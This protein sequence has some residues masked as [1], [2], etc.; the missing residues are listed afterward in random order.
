MDFLSKLDSA[1]LLNSL[2]EPFIII[3]LKGK[4]KFCNS[5]CEEMFGYTTD[6]LLDQSINTLMLEQDAKQHDSFLK[7][8]NTSAESKIIGSTSE[9]ALTGKKRDGSIFPVDIKITSFKHQ[10][11]D[12][13]IG[14]I[15][16]LTELIGTNNRL[17]HVLTSTDTVLYT[18]Q[19][20]NDQLST[21]W[22]SENVLQQ[23]GYTLDEALTPGWWMQNLH[24]EDSAQAT[25]NFDLFL[26]TGKL[27]HEYRFKTKNKG[28][29]W[30]QDKLKLIRNSDPQLIHGSWNDISERKQLL[31]NLIKSEDRLAKSQVFAN[32]GTWD[33]NIQTGELYWSEMIAPLFG[34][35]ESTLESS[36]AN[37]VN[38][39][40]P[41][42]KDMVLSAMTNCIE[43]SSQYDVE[44]RIIWPDG[45][46]RW[47]HE[48]GDVVRNENDQPFHMLGVVTDIHE[49]K[50][51]QLQQELNQKLLNTLHEALTCFTLK[52]DHRASSEILLDGL[53]AFTDSEYGFIGEIKYRENNAP[54]LKTDAITDISWN[55]PTRELYD[56]WAEKGFEFSNMDT[57]FGHVITSGDVVVSNSPATDPRA[58]GLPPGHPDMNSFLGMPVYYGDKLIGMY[59][60]ANRPQGYEQYIIDSLKLFSSTYAS[61]VQAKNDLQQKK[62]SRADL[63]QAKE[64]A[65][66]AN[67]AKS[68]FLSSMSHELRTPLNAISGFSQLLNLE[69]NLSDEARENIKD[70]ALAGKH[71]LA[72]INDV[73]DLAKIE[74]GRSEV[75]IEPI[76]ICDLF[77]ACESLIA[78]LAEEFQVTVNFTKNCYTDSF[79][80]A[81]FTKLKQVLIN[82]ISNAIKYNDINGHVEISCSPITNNALTVSIKDN[83]SGIAESDIASLFEPFNRLG[84]ESNSSI[85][86][87]GI[88]LTITRKLLMQMHGSIEVNSTL[89]QGSEFSFT[90]PAAKQQSV[91]NTRTE[92]PVTTKNTQ[93]QGKKV[94]Y[95][96]D[97]LVNLRMVKQLINKWTELEFIGSADPL[98]GIEEIKSCSPDIILLDINLPKMNGY[99][100][101]QHLKDNNICPAAPVFA[102]TANAMEKDVIKIKAAGFDEYISK[103]INIEQLLEKLNSAID[104]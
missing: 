1:L 75:S 104:K 58:K 33:W 28:Y 26:Q 91:K 29:I 6:E 35:K 12:Y 80:Q 22:T 7:K 72:L 95:I 90:L 82:L 24:P 83:G 64:D 36:Y 31:S 48:K 96:E 3:D 61:I 27:E 100:V 32:I 101:L 92:E 49:R 79:I 84:A 76:S 19:L 65:E 23:T 77:S 42:D 15:R 86:G 4:I 13:V 97:N 99:Q 18:L 30:I 52:S 78:P 103:P 70:I 11:N 2:S 87:T 62:Q 9:R 41:D 56:S 88:G 38:A 53:L 50:T 69:E 47:I 89:G 54:Y 68:I 20:H 14:V 43:N 45:T 63:V 73:L 44:H 25:E 5:A 46:V 66:S 98:F 37:F 94:Y 17:N 81:D 57:L 71:L 102:V 74:S 16:D 67:K 51:L 40:H 85:E 8:Y 59:G 93:Q 39:I 10:H 21:L 34:Y 60:L 55:E